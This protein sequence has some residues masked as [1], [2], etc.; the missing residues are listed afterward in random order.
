MA[1]M[2]EVNRKWVRGRVVWVDGVD[3]L[4]QQKVT[5]PFVSS[6]APVL[7]CRAP[8]VSNRAPL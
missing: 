8:V 2:V 5:L 7:S 1:L 6:P 4:G 3:G